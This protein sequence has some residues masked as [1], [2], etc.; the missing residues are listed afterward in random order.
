MARSVECGG[1]GDQPYQRGPRYGEARVCETVKLHLD[2]VNDDGIAELETAQPSCC[3][4]PGL[5]GQ[6]SAN[7]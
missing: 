6:L 7:W 2:L 3:A 4:I 1:R 5:P